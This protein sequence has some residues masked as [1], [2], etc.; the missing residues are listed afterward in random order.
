MLLTATTR[1]DGG[2]IDPRR[3][4]ETR[5]KQ[6]PGLGTGVERGLGLRVTVRTRP[7]VP[8][9]TGPLP[10]APSEYQPNCAPSVTAASS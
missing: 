3:P 7:A 9:A 5:R 1:V 6:G 8:A 10:L 2:L 4:G